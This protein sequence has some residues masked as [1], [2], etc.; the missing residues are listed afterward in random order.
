MFGMFKYE[1][2]SLNYAFISEKLG[3][4]CG[5]AFLKIAKS[6]FRSKFESEP[7]LHHDESVKWHQV[8]RSFYFHWNEPNARMSL[9]LE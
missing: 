7:P 2:F 6:S 5:V 4:L 3:G 8:L 9:T 1:V